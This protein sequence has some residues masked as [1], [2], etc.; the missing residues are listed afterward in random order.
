MRQA[1]DTRRQDIIQFV[2]DPYKFALWAYPWNETSLPNS[3]GPRA[4]QAQ[5]LRD[6][7]DHLDNPLTQYQPFQCAVSSGHGIGKS[8]LLAFIT[9]WGMATC[10]D[11][12]VLVTAGTGTQLSTKTVP[13]MTKWFKKSIIS[14]WFDT[15]AQSITFKSAGHEQLWRADF[16]TWNAAD[17][18]SFAG[19]HNQGKRIIVIYDEA[20]TID[21][22]IWE[23]TQ[24]ALTDTDTEIFWFACSQPTETTG[25][26]R[27][28]FGKLKHRWRGHQIDSRNVEGTNKEEFNKWIE[29]WGEDSDFVR[30][31]VKG[32]F[33]RAS[34][35]QLIPSDTVAFCRKYKAQG[36]QSLP[37]VLAV[38]VARYGDDQ[39]V[40]G[41]RQGRKFCILAKCRGLSTVQSAER[42]IHEIELAKKECEPYDAWIIDGDGLG[43]GVVD[44]LQHRGYTNSLFEFHGASTPQ[45][46]QAYFNRRAECWGLMADWLKAGAEIP[47]DPE[48]EADLTGPQYGF[49]SKQQIQLERK[50]DMKKRG[51]S[52]PDCGDTLAMTFGV[53][54]AARKTEQ[55]IEYRPR[56]GQDQAW[57]G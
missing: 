7:R 18:Q 24:G 11:C 15:K 52:S 2:R 13:E 1:N 42:V 28:C 30:V 19:L 8:A 35:S 21:D 43:A 33:P 26:F 54:I 47:D 50:E 38:D 34:I 44:Q 32:E 16:V 9:Q 3:F 36:Y 5:I 23:T 40:L 22:G 37:K 51:L 55:V 6:M 49:S 29:D 10:T 12:K 57:M 20:S 4:W 46:G 27:E 41:W 45:D 39:T 25:R 53:R 48:L 56:D 14:D 17:P 31:R